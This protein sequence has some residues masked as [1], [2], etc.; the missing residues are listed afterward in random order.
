VARP[1]ASGLYPDTQAPPP[2]R[3]ECL[4][5]LC[6]ETGLLQ[7]SLHA[8]PD[9]SR[10]YCTDDNARAL[11]LGCV[12]GKAGEPPLSEALKNRFAAFLQ[13]AWNPQTKRFR[14]FL[15]F[16]RRWLEELGSEDSHGRAL[17]ALGECA[18]SDGN[19]LRRLW[20]ASLFAQALPSVQSFTSPRAW[21]F[22]L[23][24]LDG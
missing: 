13:H 3:L 20:A 19:G 14:N 6:D 21:S 7:H 10:G 17:W 5:S 2:L 18:R 12:L 4:L 1:D 23:L 9:R 16:D 11:L 8:V 24:G 22:T 15:G